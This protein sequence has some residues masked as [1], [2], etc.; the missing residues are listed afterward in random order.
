MLLF[1]TKVIFQ[2]LLRTGGTFLDFLNVAVK[3]NKISLAGQLI[4]KK[5]T[6]R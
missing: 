1:G 5:A 6:I 4:E 3:S 2:T